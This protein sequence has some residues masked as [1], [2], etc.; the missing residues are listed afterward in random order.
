M[1]IE[2]APQN[3][4]VVVEPAAPRA[5]TEVAGQFPRRFS[6][7]SNRAIGVLWI[8]KRRPNASWSRTASS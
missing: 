5:D 7:S 2:V 1:Q 4:A 3:G 8:F 6:N